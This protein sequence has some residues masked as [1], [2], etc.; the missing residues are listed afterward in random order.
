MISL[1]P[2]Q[3]P[4]AATLLRSLKENRVACDLSDTGTGKTYTAAH[5]AAELRPEAVV[6]I[7]P[8]AVIPVWQRV[9]GEA[10]VTG[11]VTNYEKLRTGNTGLGK[12][13]LKRWVWNVPQRTLLIFD[14]AH[15]CKSASSQNARILMASK[16]FTVLALSA[17]LAQD[18]TEMR[19]IGYLLSLHT[20]TNFYRWCLRNGCWKGPFGG[21]EFKKKHAAKYLLALHEQ[22]F[23][24]F[25]SRVRIADL[26]DAFPDNQVSAEVYSFGNEAAV[27]AA[28]DAAAEEKNRR[29]LADEPVQGGVLLMQA[30]QK[31]EVLKA[32]GLVA[33]AQDLIAEGSSVVLFTSFRETLEK[34]R[35]KLKCDGVYGGQSETERQ[36]AIDDFQADKA[37]AIVVNIQAGGVGISL[38]DL[39]GTYPR[40]S[41]ICP[42]DHAVDLKQALGRIHRAGAKSKSI[43]KIV[44]AAGTYEERVCKRTQGK[45]ANIELLQDGDLDPTAELVAAKILAE[46]CLDT[47]MLNHGFRPMSAEE[48]RAAQNHFTC[49]DDLSRENLTT[50]ENKVTGFSGQV[51]DTSYLSRLPTPDT[52]E[53]PPT[54]ER[55]HAS[56]SPSA[57]KSKAICVGFIND[58]KGDKSFAERGTFGHARVE[59]EDVEVFEQSEPGEQEDVEVLDDNLELKSAVNTDSASK[60][61]SD[62]NLKAA[63]EKCIEYKRRLIARFPGCEVHQEIRFDYYSQ[64]GFA[65]LVLTDNERAI[66][67]DWKFAVNPYEADSPQF[68]A[69]CAG[70][71]DKWPLV[72]EIEVHVVHPFFTENEIDK[73]TFT[74][75]EHYHNF[76]AKI[77]AIT[78]RVYRNDPADYVPCKQCGYCGLAGKCSALARLGVEVHERYS[79]E[80]VALPFGSLH[81]SEI[82]DPDVFAVLLP[83]RA[84]LRKA[85][86]SWGHAATQMVDDGGDIP[87][88]EMATKEGRRS[89][90]SAKGVFEL[91]KAEIAPQLKAE[92]FLEDCSIKPTAIDGIVKAATKR[93]KKGE[94]VKLFEAR[95]RDAGLLSR[96]AGS[97]YLRPTRA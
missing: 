60:F 48:S 75:K 70:I 65:D 13:E 4:S 47:V 32:D 40:V 76:Y 64:W 46:P 41:L 90:D 80:K 97:R 30:R 96:S 29:I 36:Q 33:M 43:Q 10:G 62:P 16:P 25:G 51:A 58:P 5:V 38:H 42:T 2:Y 15:R 71:W 74:R 83:V 17:T 87:G 14:E 84:P 85:L 9:L 8:K 24:R 18:P 86:G 94:S 92:E 19:A 11:T 34:L 57:L 3:V 37:R 93:G 50:T 63:V 77:A 23:P 68:W 7:C 12:F 6:V 53:T 69:Y 27:N 95:L 26:G 20:W 88:Y 44:F 55:K 91:L 31:A 67:A 79:G 28:Y 22:I 21:I 72:D 56:L 59:D 78:Q 66:L 61:A 39:H 82:D 73:E 81:G 1:Y 89:I 52:V 35:I 45:L 54:K 49:A